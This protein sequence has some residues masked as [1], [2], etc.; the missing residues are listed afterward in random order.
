MLRVMRLFV[1]LG[2][3]LAATPSAAQCVLEGT[4]HA[5]LRGSSG[6]AV[7]ASQP[8]RVTL[9]GATATLEGQGPLVFRR[10]VPA[11]RVRLSLAEAF[12]SEALFGAA[13]GVRVEVSEVRGVVVLATLDAGA[14]TLQGASLPCRALGLGHTHTS[15]ATAPVMAP[16]P[17][18][19]SRSVL[20]YAAVCRQWPGGASCAQ[21]LEPGG[22]CRPRRDG[23]QCG[24]HPVGARL[25]VYAAPREDSDF[26][27]L[28]ATRDVVFTD[29][30][31]RP[32]WIR[33]QSRGPAASG[34]AVHAWARA[35]DVRWAQEVPPSSREPQ[36][37]R[38]MPGRRVVLS[39][40]RGL[41]MIPPGAVVRD[42]T[43][44]ELARVGAAP[45][46]TRAELPR[47]AAH[48]LIALPGM[49]EVDDGARVDAAGLTWVDACPP[50]P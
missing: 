9:S 20:R 15:T 33:L 49:S 25:R 7:Y 14:M 3:M 28:T 17:R 37:V 46:C 30:D 5:D 21:Q 29:D 47:G 13:A 34:L 45:F 35:R 24:Y 1:C 12:T 26:V 32:G 19:R 43:G 50:A 23:S 42:G 39:S 22:R 4:A 16:N 18:W 41:A 36:R 2:V 31:G 10:E 38:S 27:T 8:L 40:R 11:T 44:A 48:A 6:A